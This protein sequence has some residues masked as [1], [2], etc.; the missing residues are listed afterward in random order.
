[1][2]SRALIKGFFDSRSVSGPSAALVN[3]QL[4]SFNDFLPHDKNQGPW[5]QRVVDNISVG[6]DKRG[7]DFAE[8]Y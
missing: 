6:A 7:D 8:T 2:N 4:G 1:M 5:M 3:H